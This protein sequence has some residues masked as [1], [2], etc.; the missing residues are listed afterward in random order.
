VDR[1]THRLGRFFT[2]GLHDAVV[3]SKEISNDAASF[4]TPECDLT[5]A[6]IEPRFP[7][8]KESA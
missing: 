2:M 1:W 5:G 4:A 3:F 7:V 6:R 8:P